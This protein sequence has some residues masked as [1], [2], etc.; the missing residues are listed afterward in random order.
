MSKLIENVQFLLLFLLQ[1][2]TIKLQV[3]FAIQLIFLFPNSIVVQVVIP[4]KH[5]DLL[6]FTVKRSVFELGFLTE[7][8]GRGILSRK[9]AQ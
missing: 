9:L 4:T 1:V 5:T 3:C 7:V 8:S 6:V 2:A